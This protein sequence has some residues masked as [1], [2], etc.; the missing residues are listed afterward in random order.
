[1]T[2]LKTPLGDYQSDISLGQKTRMTGKDL[3]VRN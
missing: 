3:L 1:M 2:L